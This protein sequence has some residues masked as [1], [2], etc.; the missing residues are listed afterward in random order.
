MLQPRLRFPWHVPCWGGRPR[1]P[2]APGLKLTAEATGPLTPASPEP[3]Q[4][5]EC[6]L[7]AARRGLPRK[8]TEIRIYLKILALRLAPPSGDLPHRARR[9]AVSL[10]ARQTPNDLLHFS[11]HFKGGRAGQRCSIFSANISSHFYP[12][13]WANFRLVHLA[14]KTK[15]CACW[16]SPSDQGSREGSEGLLERGW[17]FQESVVGCEL[18]LTWAT[19]K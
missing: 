4:E 15:I 12:Q 17:R 7:H 5:P 14:S 2:N 3:K 19:S 16:P 13:F 18:T 11:I 1:A 10:S 6:A 9:K 8:S